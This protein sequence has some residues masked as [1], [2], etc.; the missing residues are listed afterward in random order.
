MFKT[1]TATGQSAAA[2]TSTMRAD[3]GR[4]GA[5]DASRAAATKAATAAT[6]TRPIQPDSIPEN[7]A[8]KLAAT[9]RTATRAIRSIGPRAMSVRVRGPNRLREP[10]PGETV[11]HRVRIERHGRELPGDAP[12]PL[13]SH[14]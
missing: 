2:K 8:Q 4:G 3:G 1:R 7:A 9:P 12:R 5:G 6:Q 11:L 10:I 14:P 13:G